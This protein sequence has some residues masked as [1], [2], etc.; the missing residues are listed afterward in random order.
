MK[1]ILATFGLGTLLSLA[2]C[3]SDG[4][5]GG[6]GGGGSGGGTGGGDGSSTC[7]GQF[8]L[9]WK[10]ACAVAPTMIA[11]RS[12]CK[13]ASGITDYCAD[14]G[15]SAPALGCLG[16]TPTAAASK[17]ITLK[18]Y[19]RV[20]SGG[21]DS[22]GVKLD[23][24]KAADLGAADALGRATVLGTTMTT[25]AQ[26]DVDAGNVRACPTKDVPGNL[27]CAKPDTDCSSPCSTALGTSG[28]QF[29]SKGTCVDRL[30]YEAPYE[31]SSIP[32]D[33]P[34]AVRAAGPMGTSDG[35]WAPLVSFRII[36]SSADPMCADEQKVDCW[37]DAGK[38][39]YR[40]HPV[41]LSRSDYQ[42]I[43]TSAGL[44]A[45]IPAGKGAVA[46]EVRDC[47]NVRIEY[48][49]VGINPQATSFTYF[50]DN[51]FKTLPNAGRLTEGTD[52][53]GL[54]AGLS[55]APGM[56]RVAALGLVN[57]ENAALGEADVVVFPDTV[58]IVLLNGG[59]PIP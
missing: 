23:V 1:T 2:A 6:G 24:Y 53:L 38:T 30:R 20:F 48:A 10:G 50:N 26:A 12:A 44:S 22:T 9:S 33:T 43:P 55:I 37:E 32:S 16:M 46:G 42:V 7:Q 21:G 40:F 39:T 28:A 57:G 25:I 18:G 34:L 58:T 52:G 36:A 13:D 56:V 54:F 45:G 51:P 11:R 41:A 27:P 29:C 3:G 59:R 4:G 14:D 47:Q 15:V 31:I 17:A 8:S 5:A 19:V 49:Q 35:K